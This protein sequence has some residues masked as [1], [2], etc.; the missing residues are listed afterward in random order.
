M[1]KAQKYLTQLFSKVNTKSTAQAKLS[2]LS[3]NNAEVLFDHVRTSRKWRLGRMD[4]RA[5]DG[6]AITYTNDYNDTELKFVGFG[7]KLDSILVNRFKTPSE[8]KGEVSC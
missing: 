7:E 3:M 1:N 8:W 2:H 6:F 5:R 4:L